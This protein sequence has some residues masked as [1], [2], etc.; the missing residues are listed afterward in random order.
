MLQRTFNDKIVFIS[1]QVVD[2]NLPVDT[3][4]YAYSTYKVGDMKASAVPAIA[5]TFVVI[6]NQFLSIGLVDQ[7]RKLVF[8]IST[9][10]TVGLKPE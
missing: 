4:L 10:R 6:L 8:L 1:F 5:F 2:S 7:Q 3:T 9:C